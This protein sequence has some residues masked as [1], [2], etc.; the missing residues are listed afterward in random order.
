M[1][2]F[3]AKN[4]GMDDADSGLML[5]KSFRARRSLG[6]SGHTFSRRDFAIYLIV[7]EH[8]E[9]AMI[10]KLEHLMGSI[11]SFFSLDRAVTFVGHRERNEL[12]PLPAT[13]L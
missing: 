3:H 4:A 10:F 2:A 9:H 1:K 6:I 12:C 13:D 8:C 5:K 11:Q 7:D